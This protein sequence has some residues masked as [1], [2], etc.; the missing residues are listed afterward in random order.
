MPKLF[1]LHTKHAQ[2]ILKLKFKNKKIILQKSK[3]NEHLPSHQ[4]C[5]FTSAAESDKKCEWMNEWGSLDS[6]M[7]VCLP[8]CLPAFSPDIW[9]LCNTKSSVSTLQMPGMFFLIKNTYLVSQL[10]VWCSI[11]LKLAV[12]VP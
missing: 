12:L 1:M 8:A 9:F 7:L 2:N 5:V 10:H 3:W 6:A 4:L 11:M